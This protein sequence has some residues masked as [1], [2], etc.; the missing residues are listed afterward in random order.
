MFIFF[1]FTDSDASLSEEIETNESRNGI[2]PISKA[3][4]DLL[5]VL[6]STSVP[7][8]LGVGT[9]R[10]G[11]DPYVTFIVHII[12]LKFITRNYENESEKWEVGEKCLKILHSFLKNYEIHPVD[13][14]ESKEENS[15]PG[16]HIMVQVHTK[17]EILKLI[18]EIIYQAREKLDT[19]NRN[20]P[21]KMSLEEC[22]L[23]CLQ[24]IELA[25]SNQ[26]LFFDAHSVANCSI[27]LSG[28]NKILLDVNPHTG[29]PDHVLN[30]TKFVTYN[31]WLPRHSLYAV[32]ILNAV[33]RQPNVT[34]HILG[35]FTYNEKTQAEIR[36]GFVECL[37]MDISMKTIDNSI[38]KPDENVELE[39]KIAIIKLL[40]DFLHLPTPNL[41]HYL[42]GF[43]ITK[44]IRSTQLQKPGIFDFPSTCAKSLVLLLDLN[45]DIMKTNSNFDPRYEEFIENSYELLYKLS[46]NQQTSEVVL[47]F[48]RTSND[49]ILRHLKVLPFKNCRSYHVLNQMSYLLKTVSIELKFLAGN[50]QVSRFQI[51]CEI[52]LGISNNS[53][54]E[55]PMEL[56]HYYTTNTLNEPSL[57]N[58]GVRQRTDQNM[59]LLI[60]YLLECLHFELNILSLPKL[61]FFDFEKI[62]KLF[63]M[64]E[65]V[66]YEGPK[67]LNVKK[68]HDILHDELNIVQNTIAAGQRIAILQEI[69]NLLKFGLNA[70]EQK[71]MNFATIKF[72]EAWGEV[73]EIL[74]GV[75]PRKALLIE[76]KQELI[77]EILQF[78]LNKVSKTNYFKTILKS[79]TQN[80][81]FCI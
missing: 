72:M 70:N 63:Q 71:R 45:I 65:I 20:I 67:L 81:I 34:S 49:F 29:C 44:D 62:I 3:I 39:L 50:G 2:Y 15:P 77:L 61:T 10:P 16:Y 19:Y 41:A 5:Y 79:N 18:L 8:T 47:R 40:K 43:D 21:G 14:S 32:K 59:R 76:V 78:I 4:L 46:S 13:F 7:K 48:L 9:R 26:D 38:E 80:P 36:H 12:F 73:T 52:L 23:Y 17:S 54:Q 25:L 31:N 11:L 33:C 69:D 68:L 66:K 30:I 51:L 55:I 37:E 6:T 35:I 22:S 60:C 24:I 56:G 64:C 58:S 53:K 28:L 74:F 27:L 1:A 75:A 42:L 57:G